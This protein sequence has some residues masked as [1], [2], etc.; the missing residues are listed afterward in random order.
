M[1]NLFFYVSGLLCLIIISC[2]KEAEPSKTEQTLNY[3]VV[4]T[5]AV[6]NIYYVSNTG[7]DNNDG[8]STGQ[9]WKTI[10]KLN[11]TTFQAG[12]QILL[13]GG[14]IFIGNLSVNGNGTSSS[15]IKFGSYGSGKAIINAQNGT[16]V[17]VYKKSYIWIDNLII[18]GGWNSNSQSGNN[19]YGI[20]YYTDQTNNGKTNGVRVTNCEVKSFRNAG[21]LVS[22]YASDNTQSGF[23]NISITD[24]SSH[25]NGDAG[26]AT[27][28]STPTY[29][30]TIYAHNNVNITRNKVY[31]N[32]GIIN[33]GTNSGS[34]IVLS[35]A[36]TATV[37]NNVAYNNGWFNNFADGGPVGIWCFD[38][39]KVV[40]EFNEA[41]NNGSST[42]DGDGFDFDGGVTNSTMQYNY[43]HD[44]YG[45][46]YLFWEYGC[47]RG[48]N[49]NNTMR[50]NISQNDATNTFYGGITMGENCDNNRIYNNTIYSNKSVPVKVLGGSGNWFTN[51]IFYSNSSGNYAT[52]INTPNCWFLSNNYYGGSFGTK[53]YYWNG[54]SGATHTSLSTFRTAGQEKYLS[55][56]YG[57]ITNPSLTNAGSGG[58]FNNGNPNVLSAYKLNSGSAM[59]NSGFALTAFGVNMG[60]LDF[61]KLSTPVGNFDIGASEKQ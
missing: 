30:S 51:N 52:I 15:Y 3:S 60:A 35:D 16:G 8:K 55:S 19:G 7:N 31:D 58:T 20:H 38:A 18:Y 10:G 17:Y 42:A 46:G 40:F 11:S 33:K 45:A 14:Q 48:N 59:I 61:N 9:A 26:I 36:S 43:S 39:D 34:G 57:F 4:K 25:G 32:L 24:N 54:T 37:A 27:Y 21:I 1:K 2:K 28:G 13:K 22:A 47:P 49:E 53:I 56:S 50:Y 5:N 41:Y 44:N 6:G 23:N 29:G 12:D